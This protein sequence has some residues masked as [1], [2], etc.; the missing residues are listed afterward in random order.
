MNALYMIENMLHY[1][2]AALHF[3]HICFIQ[4]IKDGYLIGIL[5]YMS[6]Y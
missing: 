3:P 2:Y 6:T 1:K 4:C 5:I